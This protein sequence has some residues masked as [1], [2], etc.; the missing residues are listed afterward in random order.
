MIYKIKTRE[1]LIF[2]VND[3]NSNL[4]GFEPVLD[5][6]GKITGYKTDLGGADTVF[7]FSR[8]E[9]IKKYKSNS[10]SP[11]NECSFDIDLDASGKYIVFVVS[12]FYKPIG[13]AEIL[14]TPIVVSLENA[15]GNIVSSND[16]ITVLNLT[17][18]G[19]VHVKIPGD[20]QSAY[21]GYYLYYVIRL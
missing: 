3:I 17:S 20:S 7:P 13:Y 8:P 12:T 4:K 19:K 18:P 10:Y 1:G 9:V 14:S 15:N 16:N 6:S 11:I 2:E 5:D 21:Y